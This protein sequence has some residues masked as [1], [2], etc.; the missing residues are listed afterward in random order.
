MRINVLSHHLSYYSI[1]TKKIL[2]LNGGE[3]LNLH[4]KIKDLDDEHENLKDWTIGNFF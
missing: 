2:Q 1:V 3:N 4:R